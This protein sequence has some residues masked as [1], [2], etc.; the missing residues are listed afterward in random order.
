MNRIDRIKSL[1]DVNKFGLE[2]G[3]SFNPI[4][5]KSEGYNVEI[6]DHLNRDQLIQNC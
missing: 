5:P 2:I 1:F 6:L 3:P 4:V